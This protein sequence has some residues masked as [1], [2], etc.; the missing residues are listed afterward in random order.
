M[1]EP[2]TILVIDGDPM[3]RSSLLTEKLAH[4]R[5]DAVITDIV[6]P[7]HEG[8][9]TIVALRA[10]AP[11]LPIIAIS[12][13]GQVI[14]AEFLDMA[15]QAGA[16]ATL[17][18]P[19]ELATLLAT[20]RACCRSLELSIRSSGRSPFPPAILSRWSGHASVRF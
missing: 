11:N 12:G 15:L 4:R 6:M 14:A 8:I 3:M 13:C 7:E 2:L 19:F 17:R 20:S 9:E 18:K 10:A 5:P 16:T 1:P